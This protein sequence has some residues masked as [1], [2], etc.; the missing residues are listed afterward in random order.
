MLAFLLCARCTRL[1]RLSSNEKGLAFC[2]P[3]VEATTRDGV[4]GTFRKLTGKDVSE[5]TFRREG[6]QFYTRHKVPENLVAFL[7]RWGSGTIRRYIAE[8]ID[9]QASQA[10]RMAAHSQ[11]QADVHLNSTCVVQPRS[12]CVG[13]LKELA[14][15]ILNFQRPSSGLNDVL[16][17]KAADEANRVFSEMVPSLKSQWQAAQ[18]DELGIAPHPLIS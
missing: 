17:S 10:A 3:S 8:A 1:S 7:G 9:F 5:H 2:Q 14:G 4:I 12:L 16:V 11:L 13:Q 18:R 15:I 6:A